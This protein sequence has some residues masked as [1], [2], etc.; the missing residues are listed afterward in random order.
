MMKRIFWT[1]LVWLTSW[2]ICAAGTNANAVAAPGA[3]SPSYPS[4]KEV[5][6]AI[7]RGLNFLLKAQ[8]SNGWW[9]T[10]DQPAVTALVLT[11]LNLE[12]SHKYQR[13]RTSEM[14]RAYD[15]LLGC[16]KADGSIQRAGLA[17]YNTSLSLVALTSAAD[18]NFMPVILAA[19]R[20]IAGT[21]IDM[22]A[23]GTNDT[24]FDGGVG[25]GSK[26][27]H[28]D[29]NNTLTAIE[30][31]R[32]SEGL[33]PQDNPT[34]RAQMP[35]LKWEAVAQFLQ[36]CQNL[37]TVNKAEWVSSDPT[38]R[39]G[40]VYYPGHSMAGGTTNADNGKVS[41][42]SYGSMSYGG[43]LSYIYA[44]VSKDDPR[45]TAVLDW[46]RSNYTLEENPGMEQQGYY[47]YLHLMTKALVAVGDEGMRLKGGKE[48]RWRDE[49][50]TRLLKLQKPDG[51]WSN[52]EPRWWEAD[53]VLVTSYAVMTLEMIDSV[54]AK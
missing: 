42:R 19:R 35:D 39:G 16:V 43:L 47:Y 9:S 44:K 1:G 45:V 30:A 53:P 34:L 4:R 25:Y 48:V 40:F 2:G 3:A 22:G 10:P 28:S 33:F 26:Y 31:M 46:L 17:N 21:Q 41:L 38:D 51:S 23:A 36:N 52:P 49:V 29:M 14:S 6:A 7:E 15:Y 13:S 20:Y 27:Q 5:S 54:Q 24:P 37:P 12:P 11:A 32:F 18:T 50:A 8:N